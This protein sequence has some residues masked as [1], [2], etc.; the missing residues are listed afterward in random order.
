MDKVDKKE[1]MIIFSN[2]PGEVS[3]WVLPVLEEVVRRQ[4]LVSRYRIILII[5]P[6]QFASGAEHIVAKNYDGLEAVIKPSEYLKILFTG[7]GKRTYSFARDGIMFSL[8][9]DLMHP[10]IF[11]RRIKGKHTLYAYTNNPG[12]EKYYEK[13]FVRSDYIKEKFLKHGC[14]KE[15]V[16]VTGDLVFDSLKSFKSRSEIRKSLELKRSERM[17]VFMPGSR[18]FEVK[19]M[20]PIFLKVIDDLTEKWDDVKPFI[21]KSPFVSCS[22]IERA[23][24]LGGKIKEIESLQGVLGG[25]SDEVGPKI[26]LAKGKYVQVLEGGLELWGEGIDFAVT[27]PGTNTVQL[28]YREIPSLVVAPMNKPEVI[29]IEGIFGLLKWVPFIGKPVLKRAVLRYIDKFPFAA[30]PNIYENEEIL[31]ELFGVIKTADITEK[32][33][34]IIENRMDKKIRKRLLHFKPHSD[35]V[36]IIVEEVWGK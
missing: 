12:W 1:D 34:E 14:P 28:A 15:K 26:V 8:G 22:M 13:I 10:I 18:D 29:P 4:D 32:I 36:G 30:L 35:P 23:L 5:H 6:C 16:I 33:N 20:L 11:R 27:L 7:I 3:T 19:Y 17:I 9:G 25:F 24:S 21:L 2:G 31:P